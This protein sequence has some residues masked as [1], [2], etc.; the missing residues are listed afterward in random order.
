M[1]FNNRL[2]KLR[3]NK[4]LSIKDISSKLDIDEDIYSKWE[5]GE[6]YPSFENIIKL[7]KLF[8]VS[9]DYL[10]IGKSNSDFF[11]KAL[12]VVLVGICLMV[13]G[14]VVLTAAKFVLK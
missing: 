5:E 7:S 4:K 6:E 8:S 13:L 14:F 1:E 3:E 12:M 9:T 2:K 11:Y 10:L